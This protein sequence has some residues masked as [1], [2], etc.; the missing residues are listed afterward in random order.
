M[1]LHFLFVTDDLLT[2]RRWRQRFK[3]N[4]GGHNFVLMAR[5]YKGPI[6]AFFCCLLLVSLSHDQRPTCKVSRSAFCV[7]RC[8]LSVHHTGQS[9]LISRDYTVPR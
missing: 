9:V 8:F 3:I 1:A 7:S 6:G 4:H 5:G 2:V